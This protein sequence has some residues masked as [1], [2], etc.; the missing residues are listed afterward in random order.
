V[1][2]ANNR[3]TL[4]VPVGTMIDVDL[5]SAAWTAPVGSDPKTLPRIS[6]ASSC[7]GVRAS[8]RVQGNGWIEAATQRGS[9]G[10]ISDIVFR[11]NVVASP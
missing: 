11:V 9:T 6:S 7:D 3:A 1:T 8:F 4:T 2:L 5:T 10:G